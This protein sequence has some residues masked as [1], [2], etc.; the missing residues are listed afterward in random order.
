VVQFSVGAMMEFVPFAT[1]SRHAQGP[2]HPPIQW[3]PGALTPGVKRPVLEAD[4]STSSSAEV[5]HHH[6]HHQYAFMTW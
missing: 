5:N 4:H 1:A 3:V 2:I 6:H